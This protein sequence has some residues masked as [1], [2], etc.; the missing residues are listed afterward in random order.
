MIKWGRQS[1]SPHYPKVELE[2]SRWIPILL[3]LEGLFVTK[4][5]TGLLQQDKDVKML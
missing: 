4:L 5:D 3:A 1:T 2:A